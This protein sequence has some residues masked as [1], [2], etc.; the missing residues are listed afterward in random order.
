MAELVG[1]VLCRPG[2]LSLSAGRTRGTLL[3]IHFRLPLPFPFDTQPAKNLLLQR[4]PHRLCQTA[5][6]SLP[7]PALAV[8]SHPST[9]VHKLGKCTFLPNLERTCK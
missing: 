5:P 2:R 7:T 8:D 6:P 3:D 1:I 9:L 4:V